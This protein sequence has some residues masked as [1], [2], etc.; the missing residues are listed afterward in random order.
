M[1]MNGATTSYLTL[2][3]SGKAHASPACE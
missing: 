3:A 2:D 1:K